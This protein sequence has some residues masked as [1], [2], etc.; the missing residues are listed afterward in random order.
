MLP[1]FIADRLPDSVEGL[2][3]AVIDWLGPHAG[4]LKQ[5][6]ADAGR[7]LAHIFLGLGI[8]V[9]AS[10][11]D[12]QPHEPLG[13]LARAM[14]ERVVRV[15]EAFRRVV[16]AQTRISAINTLLTA[17]Y[18]F[19]ALRLAGVHMPLSKTV[20][21]ITFL[22]GL[23]PVVGNLVS[24][25]LDRDFESERL[26]AGGDRIAGIPGGHPQTRIFSKRAYD[27]RTGALACVGVIAGDARHGSRVWHPRS[28]RGADL[29]RVR[30]R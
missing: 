19:V 4:E 14:Q 22:V 3:E 25:T 10:V 21:V 13:P 30:Q 8:G 28:H 29:L 26:S 16:F 15:G 9:L 23:L 17:L 1:D 5:V 24:N 6:G 11:H 18:L 7:T 12:V 2:R 27:R 20:L